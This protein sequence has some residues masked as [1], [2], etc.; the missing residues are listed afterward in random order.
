VKEKLDEKRTIP[1]NGQKEGCLSAVGFIR[2]KNCKTRS[3]TAHFLSGTTLQLIYRR[4]GH[5]NSLASALPH[6]QGFDFIASSSFI[7]Q[8]QEILVYMIYSSLI[9]RM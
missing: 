1:G 6:N 2:T 4:V 3:K 9:R 5:E 7:I 8:A